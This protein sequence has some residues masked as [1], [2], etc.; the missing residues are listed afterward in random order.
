MRELWVDLSDS[1]IAELEG[2][3][4]LKC[5]DLSDVIV[6]SPDQIEAARSSGARRV[7]A[8]ET[9]DIVLVPVSDAERIIELKK[10]GLT[11]GAS[12]AIQ[13]KE[14]LNKIQPDSGFDYLIVDCPNWRII[15]TENLIALSA[16][17]WKLIVRIENPNEAR[18]LLETLELGADG[19]LINT[20]NAEDLESLSETVRTV[21][22]RKEEIESSSRLALATAKVVGTREVGIGARVCV[23][24]CSLMR[25]GEG[26]LVG[27]Q[28]SGL[29]LIQAEVEE[30]PHVTPRPF[31]VNAGPVSSYV[32]VSPEKTQYLCEL[33][34]GDEL[35]TVDREGRTRKVIVGRI[36]VEMRPFTLV[37]CE[38]KGS[39][40][41]SIV[42]NA[43]T[44]RYVTKDGSKAVP[45]IRKDDELVVW[46]SEGGRHFGALVGKETVLEY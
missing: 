21:A 2:E 25:K 28:S 10:L 29:F 35:M 46:V 18:S 31:R 27:S 42:Q 45:D 14:D 30:N 20:R 24:T 3:F 19:V 7:A 39:T 26:M 5:V 15:P 13:S 43:E 9:A 4:H 12:I 44:V 6:V 41:K 16:E 32:A 34:G 38:Y 36:K 11:V 40:L 8:T 23:D 33:K 17:K 37:V 1:Q 22:T